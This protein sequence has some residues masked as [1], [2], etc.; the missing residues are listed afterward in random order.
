MLD[1]FAQLFQHCWG[2]A[3]SLRMVYKDL[4]FVSFPRCTVGPTL[5]GVGAS[6][7]TPLPTRTQQLPTL[8]AQQCWELL[9]PFIR[10]LRMISIISPRNINA[11]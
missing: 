1:P 3:R 10:S 11:L 8:L 7:R 6:V 9:R 4:W 2:Y 5:L